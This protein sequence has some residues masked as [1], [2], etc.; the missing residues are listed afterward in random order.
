ML[1]RSQYEKV[2]LSDG[3]VVYESEPRALE[4]LDDTPQDVRDKIIAVASE[5][6]MSDRAQ[7]VAK[8]TGAQIYWLGADES[9]AQI[10]KDIAT[11]A[12]IEKML[13]N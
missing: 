8:N 7:E 9:A 5:T 3:S 4:H 2:T 13:A 12:A 11:T 10:E 1:F 6:V